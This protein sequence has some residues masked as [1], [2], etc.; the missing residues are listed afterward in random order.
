MII[1]FSSTNA[2]AKGHKKNAG[3]QINYALLLKK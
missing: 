1:A 2:E 3:V